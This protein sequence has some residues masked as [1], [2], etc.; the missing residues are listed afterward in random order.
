MNQSHK[1]SFIAVLIFIGFLLFMAFWGIDLI[2]GAYAGHKLS[3]LAERHHLD[4]RYDKIRLVGLSTV[5]MEGLTVIPIDADTLIHADRLQAK[6]ELG[7]LLLLTPSIESVQ[8]D[9]L[10]IHFI[11]KGERANF[12]FLYKP[13]NHPGELEMIR[14]GITHAR[15]NAPLVSFS[16]YCP[17]MPWYMIYVFLIVI[18]EMN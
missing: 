17:E 3:K 1:R 11:K 5:R 4:I 16:I 2:L 15:L 7:R 13:S 9:N 8:A 10:H 18:K 14:N 12:D 6:L